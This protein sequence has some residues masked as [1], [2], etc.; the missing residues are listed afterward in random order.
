VKTIL[1]A[2]CC[3]LSVAVASA[4]QKP[5]PP[6]LDMP[7]GIPATPWH[8]PYF[9]DPVAH[10]EMMQP[11]QAYDLYWQQVFK[12]RA[13]RRLKADKTTGSFDPHYRDPYTGQ[14]GRELK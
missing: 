2:V 13:Q 4:Q 8:P 5:I 3:F 14:M 12:L 9:G 7:Y 6:K 10:P 1:T 11:Q